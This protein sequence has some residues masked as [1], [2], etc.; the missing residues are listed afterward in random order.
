VSSRRWSDLLGQ[1]QRALAQDAPQSAGIGVSVY[2]DDSRNWVEISRITT[3]GARCASSGTTPRSALP[4]TVPRFDSESVRP[5]A[6]R[7]SRAD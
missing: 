1:D 6:A 5:T 7:A 4:Q 2:A 3:T